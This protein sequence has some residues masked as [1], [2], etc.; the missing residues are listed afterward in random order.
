MELQEQER[1]RVSLFKKSVDNMIATSEESY[2]N[3]RYF[4]GKISAGLIRQYTDEEIDSIIDSGDVDSMRELS[5]SY[6][7]SSGFYR[8]IL[9]YYSYFLK[10]DHIVIPHFKKKANASS[11][12][13]EFLST[14][15]SKSFF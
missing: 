7:F 10:Y 12:N 6:F 1:D 8:R 4:S 13:K 2:K 3:N 11:K 5:R 14:R 15:G 9:F